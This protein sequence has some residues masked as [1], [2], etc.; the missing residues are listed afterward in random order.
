MI[1]AFEHE[2]IASGEALAISWNEV[3]RGYLGDIRD[4]ENAVV[5]APSLTQ[6]TSR[7][8]TADQLCTDTSYFE[9]VNV[10]CTKTFHLEFLF[11]STFNN[12]ILQSFC[13]K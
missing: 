8:S 5:F 12:L 3:S 11:C 10:S 9:S 1:G 7:P 2:I 6:G 13:F 4:W